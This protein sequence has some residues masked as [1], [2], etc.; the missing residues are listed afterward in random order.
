MIRKLFVLV[1][2][3][4]PGVAMAQSVPEKCKRLE[5][6]A[7]KLEWAQIGNTLIVEATVKN[8]DE[9]SLGWASFLFN[10]YIGDNDKVGQVSAAISNLA[11]GDETHL[12]MP[13]TLRQIDNIRVWSVN[14]TFVQ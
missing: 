6:T 13:T 9:Y 1:L 8:N 10:L 3:L 5:V 12:K 14:C 11:S 7:Y 4:V 2:A